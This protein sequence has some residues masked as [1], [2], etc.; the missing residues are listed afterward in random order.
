MITTFPAR[1]DML[2][3]VSKHC[4]KIDGGN[5]IMA[6]NLYEKYK[7]LEEKEIEKA[8]ERLS[9]LRAKV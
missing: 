7:K 2:N 4:E 5:C 6:K 1:K 3:Y 9:K 8:K